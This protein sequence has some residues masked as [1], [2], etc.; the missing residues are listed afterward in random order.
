MDIE[1]VVVGESSRWVLNQPRISI[2]RDPQCE[3]RL[4]GAQYPSV[5]GEHIALAVANGTVRLSSFGGAKGTTYLNDNPAGEG[6]VVRSGDVLRLGDG[7][8]ELRIRLI[9]KESFAQPSGHEP[10]RVMQVPA[11]GGYDQGRTQQYEPTR[12]LSTIGNTTPISVPPA[13]TGI[14][15]KSGYET[16]LQASA[17]TAKISRPAATPPPRTPEAPVNAPAVHTPYEPTR[18]HETRLPTPLPAATPAPARAIDDEK[19]RTLEGKL[20]GMRMILFANL[21]LILG[22][23]VLVFMQSRQLS[24]NRQDLQ[25]LRTQAQTAVSQFTPSL[26]ARLDIFERRMD[27][28]DA[29]MR[30]AQERMASGLDARMKGVEDRMI[31]RI[32][33]EVPLM[34]DKYISRKLAEVKH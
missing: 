27:G 26:D 28:V 9:E 32:D 22:L 5:L 25:E 20:N 19:L 17:P 23:L 8:P 3:V 11:P 13:P 4:S 10:T 18:G 14:L 29:E 30:A 7:G 15:G 16:D 12:V 2:G 1:I 6:F 34:L 21:A 31:G 24:Q 33:T